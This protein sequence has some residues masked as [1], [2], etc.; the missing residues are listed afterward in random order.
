VTKTK[1]RIRDYYDTTSFS[2]WREPVTESKEENLYGRL[3][4]RISTINES[5]VESEL[6]AERYLFLCN[7]GGIL[8]VAALSKSDMLVNSSLF[9]GIN[10]LLF[11]LGIIGVGLLKWARI[12]YNH[13][14]K[15]CWEKDYQEF[16]TG[17]LNISEFNT[18][19]YFRA[20]NKKTLKN[21]AVVTFVC[22]FAAV[23]A[24][25]GNLAWESIY[26]SQ[27]PEAS[28]TELFN[29][30]MSSELRLNNL[31]STEIKDLEVKMLREIDN[32]KETKR[33]EFEN[34][35]LDI[36]KIKKPDGVK[37]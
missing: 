24:I 7:A 23:I 2:V 5:T 9:L 13:N 18:R 6:S 15:G 14:V 1:S 22:Y 31:L 12:H 29:K 33:K 27:Q 3:N 34:G 32:V 16:V 8:S 26:P 35:D 11:F 25:V 30:I 17:V 37:D 19:H 4:D 20:K 36:E 28:K 21:L 10:Y